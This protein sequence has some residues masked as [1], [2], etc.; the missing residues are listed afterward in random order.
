[1]LGNNPIWDFDTQ[2]LDN[3]EEGLSLLQRLKECLGE[4]VVNEEM[5]IALRQAIE[6]KKQEQKDALS[7]D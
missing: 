6:N 1:M 5:E 4:K 2:D 7:A 3:L